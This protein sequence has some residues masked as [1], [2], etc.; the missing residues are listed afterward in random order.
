MTKQRSASR[1]ETYSD[2]ITSATS[3]F[4]TGPSAL[5]RLH[6]VAPGRVNVRSMGEEVGIKSVPGEGMYLKYIGTSPSI[7]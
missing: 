3:P 5:G 2:V 6:V 1:E 7:P 4:E